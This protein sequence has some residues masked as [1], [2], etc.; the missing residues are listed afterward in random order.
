MVWKSS[1]EEDYVDDEGVLR[2]L[3]QSRLAFEGGDKSALMLCVYRCAA[4]QAVIPDWAADALIALREN[5]ENGS[6]KD[7]NNAFGTPTEKINIRAARAKIKE[8]KSP[9]LGELLALRLLG[10]SFNDAEMFSEV[11]ENLRGRGVKVNHRDVQIIYKT[12]GGY[13]KALPR[14]PNPDDTYGTIFLTL[15]KA[16]RRGRNILRD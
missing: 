3:E 7:F 5:I 2:L 13:L 11:V 9:V 6:V 8:L 10:R 14:Y 4:F 1:C 12:Y 16:R 15:P